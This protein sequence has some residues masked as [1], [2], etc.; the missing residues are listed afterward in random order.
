MVFTLIGVLVME[1]VASEG[2]KSV[3][4]FT[5]LD[6]STDPVSV[7]CPFLCCSSKCFLLSHQTRSVVV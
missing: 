7:V 1:R 5:A 4:I 6:E 3:A 2:E